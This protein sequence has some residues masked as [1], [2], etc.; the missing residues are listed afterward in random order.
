MPTALITG[1]TSGI[2]AAFAVELASANYDLVL[3]ARDGQRLASKQAEITERFGVQVETIAA[4]LADTAQLDRVVERVADATAPIDLLINNAGFG[5][6]ADVLDP[7]L[8]ALSEAMR[9]M[10]LAV[11]ALGGAA[12]RAMRER[13]T[14]TIINVSSLAAWINRGSYSAIK[15]W[16]RVYSQSLGN[17]LHGTGVTVTALCPGWVRTE[18]HQRAGIRTGSIPSWYWVGAAEV[19][20]RGLA[21][22]RRGA[23][24]SIP[25]WRWRISH[26]LLKLAPRGVVDAVSRALASTRR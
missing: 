7:D 26:L 11:F 22:A 2:G 25:A 3:V 15:A 4:D 19:A 24:L 13:G 10:C 8:P 9:V 14:G 16:V 23:V 17:D 18:F 1:G 5:V 21:D 6:R 12:G 20:K